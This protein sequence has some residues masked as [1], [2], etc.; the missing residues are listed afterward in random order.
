MVGS[1]SV[2][3]LQLKRYAEVS[4]IDPALRICTAS[5]SDRLYS[6]RER[7]KSVFINEHMRPAGLDHSMGSPL[8]LDGGRFALI[9]VHQA[10]SRRRFDEDDIASLERISPHVARTLQLRRS[11]LDLRRRERTFA[12]RGEEREP[13]LIGRADSST[14]FVNKAA[15]AVAALSDGLSLDRLGRPLVKNAAA[16]ASIARME[17]DVLRG[18]PGGFVR[19]P[20]PSGARDYVPR[21]SRLPGESGQEL[22]GRGVLYAIH[23]ADGRGKS[24]EGTMALMLGVP[25]GPAKVV[26]ALLDGHDLQSYAAAA[27]ITINT[28]RCHL[29]TAFALTGARSQADL[30]RSSLAMLHALGSWART[31]A[32]AGR[33]ARPFRSVAG[34]RSARDPGR[35]HLVRRWME[36][37]FGEREV[38]QQQ[39]DEQEG[40]RAVVPGLL[41]ATTVQGDQDV[42]RHEFLPCPAD[43]RPKSDAPSSP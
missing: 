29:K 42:R 36:H 24:C 4:A 23:D 14:I 9:G 28:V 19:V 15:R 10:T 32:R 1:G 35:L 39:Q 18:G 43:Y 20:R 40:E 26:A 38:E 27:G 33:L 3:A 25:P 41:R 5:T 37:A 31:A 7:R 6:E 22:A 21:A 12:A 2:D 11:F 8:V 13:G 16:A 34:S 30:V 17:A